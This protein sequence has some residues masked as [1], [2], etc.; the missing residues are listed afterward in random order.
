[1]TAGAATPSSR[2]LAKERDE[3][4]ASPVKTAAANQKVHDSL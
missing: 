3:G 1:M 2:F 4:V